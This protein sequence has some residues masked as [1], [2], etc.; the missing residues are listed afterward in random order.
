MHDYDPAILLFRQAATLAPGRAD[1]RINLAYALLKTGE[2]EGARDA[3]GEAMRIDPADLHVALEY[4]FLCY[5][6]K[7]D[8]PA[9]KAE[10]RRIFAA[11]RDS[12]SEPDKNADA[13][14][15]A[16]AAF[17]NIDDPL[18]AGIERWQQALTTSA[19]SFSAHYELAQL[20]EQR[21]ELELA[22]A[23]YKAAFRLLP[24]RKAVLLELARVEKTRGN[25]EG[26]MAALMAA[27][28][29]AEPRAAELA[30]ERLPSR[31]PYV[32]EFR[33]ALELDPANEA[34]RSELAYLLLRMSQNGQAARD[35]AEKEFAALVAALPGD[36][37]ITSQLGLLYL[38]D[39]R[40]D[41]AMPLLN[42]VLAQGSQ[43]A[44]NRV[45]MTLHLPLVLE[46]S[47][48]VTETL[49]PRVLGER[50]YQAGFLKD[51]LRYFTLARQANPADAALALKLGWTNNLLHDDVTALSWFNVARQS[52]DPAIAAEAR[53]AWNNLK[54]EQRRIRSTVWLYPLLS[55]RWGDLFGYGQLK[56]ELRVRHL[57]MH[58]Y[59]SVRLAGDARRYTGG[60]IPQSLSESAFITAAGVATN[61]WHRA[62]FWFEA[63]VAT[64]Y[65]DGLHWSDYRGGVSY[66]RTRGASLAGES[67]GWFLETTGDSVYISHFGEDVI[68]YAQARAGYTAAT[69]GIRVQ[70]FWNHTL[71][72]DVRRQYWANFT[73][74][75][76]GIRVHPPG[77]P[78]PVWINLSAVRGVYLRNEGNPRRPNFNDIRL[79]IWYAF[80]K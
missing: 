23:N 34:L 5:E 1:I 67:K 14:T 15:T 17:R 57:P 45:R 28:R 9:R 2:S 27:S 11:V 49:D 36:E 8:A 21:D 64:G 50:S 52:A 56:T 73:E 37:G 42:R 13:R 20:A 78:A 59:A 7:D 26:M 61:P 63:G 6:A 19:P 79:G 18:R 71:T 22:A 35:D 54:P 43:A 66:A 38:E 4:A 55:S 44:A 47:K 39:Q 16:A 30:R 48:A 68:N 41:L 74:T 58:P 12:A 46:Q 32:Y 76:P 75:G 31:Y 70:T 53:R 3:F 60:P 72:L 69:R 29:G 10:A 25:T 40:P 51:A 77:L 24:E 80:T 65:L 62:T 33:Q